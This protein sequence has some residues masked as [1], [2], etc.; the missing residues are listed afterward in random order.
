MYQ[1]SRKILIFLVVTF[2]AVTITTVV[3][4]AI[5]SSHLI[6]GKLQSNEYIIASSSHKTNARWSDLI[7][8]LSLLYCQRRQFQ[9]DCR[10]LD[11]QYG[12]GS[13]RTLPRNM[14]YCNTLH[15]TA[16]V[17]DRMENRGLLHGANKDPCALLCSVSL[18][19]HCM[20]LFR[21][22]SKHTSFVVVSFFNIGMLSP[23][24]SVCQIMHLF[25]PRLI[26][27][28]GVDHL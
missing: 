22:N 24:N 15:W 5:Q 27:I 17:A 21:S 25:R 19:F 2:L 7:W 18:Q 26:L 8:C 16:P 20:I 1:R 4:V 13:P 9:C 12:M 11:T 6:W 28:I 10:G 23:N 14:D 3:I